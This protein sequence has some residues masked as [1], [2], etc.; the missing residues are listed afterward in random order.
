MSLKTR[1]GQLQSQAGAPPPSAPRTDAKSSLHE[2]L[3]HVRSQRISGISARPG[4][5]MSED[6]LALRLGGNWIANG[7]LEI[8]ERVTLEKLPSNTAQTHGYA[9]P[10]LPGET[11]ASSYLYIDTETTGLSGGSGTLAFL[12]GLAEVSEGCIR[13]SQYLITRFAAEAPLLAT[14]LERLPSSHRLV[15]YNGKAYDLPL[16]ITRLRMQGKRN[17]IASREHLDLL[18]PV[19]RLFK[20]RWQ[21]CRLTTVE[22]QLLNFSRQN[23]L[24]GAEAPAAWFAFMQRRQGEKLVQVVEHNRQDIL[25]LVALHRALAKAIAEPVANGVDFYGLARWLAETNEAK[26]LVL[27]SEHQHRLCDDSKRL[28]GVLLRRS[29]HGDKARLIWEELASRGCIDSIERLAKYHEHVSRNLHSALH[30][31]TMLP[32]SSEVA[33]R[34]RRIEKKLMAIKNHHSSDTKRLRDIELKSPNDLFLFT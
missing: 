24:P 3:N 33:H 10:V 30:Y 22:R 15:S 1:L 18:H 27:L 16:L 13:L 31:C 32:G 29:Q 4:R 12:V 20:S 17:D 5:R 7:L 11:A 14:L 21:D 9:M 19:R 23:D 8:E 2:R 26:A 6:E 34:R 28:L 25:S